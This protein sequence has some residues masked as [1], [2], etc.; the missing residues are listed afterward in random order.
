MGV[1]MEEL[2]RF[3]IG[4][5]RGDAGHA[6]REMMA[7]SLMDWASVT[8]AGT[9]EPVARIMRDM[10]VDDGGGAQ[11]SVAGLARK[12]PVRAAAMVN[13]T[14][15]HALDYDDTHFAH[16]GHPS[17]AVVPAA[18]AI[19]EWIEAPGAD[20]LDAALIGVEG[21]IRMGRWLGRSH[22]QT[23]FHQ[24]ATAGAF[25]ATLAAGRL[26]ALSADQMAHALGLCATRAAGLKSQF[27]TMGK[28]YHAGLA[29]QTGVEVARAAKAGFVSTLDGI[30]G[31]QGFGRTHAAQADISAIEGLGRTWDILTISH[32]FHACCHGTHAMLEA[33][34]KIDIAAPDMA[35]MQLWTHP[36]WMSVCNIPHPRTGLEVKFSYAHCAAMALSGLDTSALDSFT[37]AIARDSYLTALASRVH[38]VADDNIAETAARIEVTMQSGAVHTSEHNLNRAMPTG[39]R[40]DKLEAKSRAL[41]G[42]R[43]AELIDA[44]GA[45]PDLPTLCALL[46]AA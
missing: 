17:V 25:G 9:G 23:G 4:P 24:T 28:P 7:L 6:A 37:D 19:A 30:E 33:L 15:S 36:R 2:S 41:L 22:Y 43:A 21:S 31:A 42:A 27:G 46:R 3:G 11:A 18:L 32:K 14:T 13:G 16:I 40:R 26:L 39:S 29:A 1:V 5:V 34:A 10:A 12:L 8:M 44:V 45:L 20:M 35:E 38:V